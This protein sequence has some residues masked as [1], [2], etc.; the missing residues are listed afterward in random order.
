MFI[1][2]PLKGALSKSPGS[3]AEIAD[4]VQDLRMR[5][6]WRHEAVLLVGE[7]VPRA[8]KPLHV[9]FSRTFS[10]PLCSASETSI[11]M[12]LQGWVWGLYEKHAFLALWYFK[13]HPPRPLT[14]TMFLVVP[15]GYVIIIL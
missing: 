8:A 12:V 15:Y 5:S 6:S 10:P 2:I 11:S 13:R 3:T 1:Y 9:L 7:A 14:K 4:P